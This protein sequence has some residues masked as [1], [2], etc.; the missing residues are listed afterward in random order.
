MTLSRSPHASLGEIDRD[1]SSDALAFASTEASSS[2]LGPLRL[3]PGEILE[4]RYVLERCIGIGGMSEVWAAQH[5]GLDREVAIKLLRRDATIHAERLRTEAKLLARLRHPAIVEIHDLG[6]L[7]DG[8]HYLVMERLRGETLLAYVERRGGRLPAREAVALVVRLLE[9]L[10]VVHA[11]GVVHRD[12]KPENVLLE[13]SG[14]RL[15]PKLVDFGI[16]LRTDP[17][18][19]RQTSAG[20]IVGTPAYLSP[21]R[22]LSASADAAADV[23]AV[24]VT[25]YEL[26][27]GRLPFHGHDM[28]HLLRAILD[29]PL[30]YPRDLEPALDG[31]LFAILSTALR[32]DPRARYASAAAMREAL[33]AWLGSERD[34]TSSGVRALVPTP[35]A[36]PR[37]PTTIPAP[38][39]TPA[40][41][42]SPAPSSRTRLDTLIREKLRRA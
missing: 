26:V 42:P 33:E 9:G 41:S 34:T 27:T 29:A 32:K 2:V 17:G 22:T 14:T 23:W 10:E 38:A 19:P 18:A 30:P 15:M 3:R 37:T 36:T 8:T 20:G 39:S 25:L 28:L 21:E 1:A 16:A 24:G 6:A 13:A 12:V 4:G 5:L 35:P 7:P 40:P 11:A 31:A